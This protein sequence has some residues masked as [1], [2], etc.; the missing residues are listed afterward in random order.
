METYPD[1]SSITDE[2]EFEYKNFE[3]HLEKCQ[4]SKTITDAIDIIF[5]N[6]NCMG[7]E[8]DVGEAVVDSINMQHRTLQQAFMRNVIVPIIQNFA[9]KN[10][11]GYYDL[12]NEAT[13]NA[14][15]ELEKVLDKYH[16]PFI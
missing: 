5:R 14:C 12:R 10:A 15:Q 6:L 4:R 11:N 9:D 16:F 7:R 8:K 13:V 1:T 2:N 3:A